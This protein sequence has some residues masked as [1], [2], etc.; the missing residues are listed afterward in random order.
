M[1]YLHISIARRGRLF[2]EYDQ[3]QLSVEKLSQSYMKGEKFLFK[4]ESF[5]P[6]DIEE[7]RIFETENRN[8]YYFGSVF[9]IGN[10]VTRHFINSP[11]PSRQ[12]TEIPLEPNLLENL[13]IIGLS[14]DWASAAVALQLQEIAITLF[15]EKSG[16]KLDKEN[17]EKTLNRKVEP[18]KTEFLA[19]SDKYEAFSQIMKKNFGQEMPILLSDLR[20]TRVGILHIGKNPTPEDTKAITVFTKDLLDKLSKIAKSK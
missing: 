4:G 16:I 8:N 12:G 11:P 18:Q 13:G 9:N 7:I 2:Y 3:T 20:R 17:V 14:K 15:A 6:Y 1:P 10:D 19:F 5:D